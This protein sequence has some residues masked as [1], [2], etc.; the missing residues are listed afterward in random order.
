MGKKG[1]LL[2]LCHREREREET[3]GFKKWRREERIR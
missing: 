2:P 1:V 3:F